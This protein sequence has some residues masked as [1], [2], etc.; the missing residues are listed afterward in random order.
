MTDRSGLGP[1][2]DGVAISVGDDGG[3]VVRGL[4]DDRS[5]A[6]MLH[7]L[8]TS[9]G[10]EARLVAEGV[11]ARRTSSIDIAGVRFAGDRVVLFDVV[12]EEREVPAPA[13]DRLLARWLRA[14]GSLPAPPVPDAVRLADAL[15]ARAELAP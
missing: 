13:F 3:L 1:I 12:D 6:S 11:A 4:P 9:D 8:L 15:D 7:A 5:L 14:L 2:L 10:D